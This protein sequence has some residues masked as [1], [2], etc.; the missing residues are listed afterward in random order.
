MPA[1][2]EHAQAQELELYNSPRFL[3][4]CFRETDQSH[5]FG[6]ISCLIA[7]TFK[8]ARLG[9]GH[10]K[11]VEVHMLRLLNCAPCCDKVL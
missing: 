1:S 10:V 4:V 5:T 9:Y 2:T 11:D 6:P 7:V 8:Y 3:L